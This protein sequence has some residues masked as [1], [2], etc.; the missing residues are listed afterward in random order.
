MLIDISGCHKIS[1]VNIIYDALAAA[2]S[3][4]IIKLRTLMYLSII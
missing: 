4:N 2:I 3:T 1:E